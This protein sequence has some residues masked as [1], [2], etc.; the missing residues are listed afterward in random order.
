MAALP[1]AANASDHIGVAN[2]GNLR[3]PN[4]EFGGREQRPAWVFRR[5]TGRPPRVVSLLGGCRCA[6]SQRTA[7]DVELAANHLLG[8]PASAIRPVASFL[9]HADAVA[10]AAPRSHTG[11][12]LRSGTL[13]RCL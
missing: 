2:A 9:R 5:R 7:V 6:R 13:A 8:S 12:K 11:G 3:S 10:N 1:G 4:R